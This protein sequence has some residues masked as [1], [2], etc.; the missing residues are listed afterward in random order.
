[1]IMIHSPMTLRVS[2]LTMKE[3]WGFIALVMFLYYRGPSR[4]L[5]VPQ[6][7]TSWFLLINEEK[8]NPALLDVMSKSHRNGTRP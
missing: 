3:T 8:G 7:T 1:M 4:S 6:R 2:P 5:F